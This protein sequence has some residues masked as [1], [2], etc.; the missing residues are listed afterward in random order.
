MVSDHDGFQLIGHRI[1]DFVVE[2]KGGFAVGHE[3]GDTSVERLQRFG[4]ANGSQILSRE[5]LVPLACID[6]CLP[7]GKASIHKSEGV[8]SFHPALMEQR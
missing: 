1:P 8:K 3:T 2:S 6:E 5:L 4:T 7:S